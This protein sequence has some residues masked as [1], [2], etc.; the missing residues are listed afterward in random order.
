M[1]PLEETVVTLL[2]VGEIVQFLS[3]I[4]NEWLTHVLLI[5]VVDITF[6]HAG[7]RN[8]QGGCVTLWGWQPFQ[9]PFQCFDVAVQYLEELLLDLKK[10][11]LN[12]N[13]KS[14]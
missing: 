7:N 2:W 1:G 9:V 6:S 3:W 8:K 10:T 14:S 5:R 4:I 12:N 11:N 13:G